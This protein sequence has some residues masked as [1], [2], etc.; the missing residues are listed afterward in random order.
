MKQYIVCWVERIG[1]TDTDH[2]QPFIDMDGNEDNLKAAQEFYNNLLEQDSTYTANLTEI[3]DS[4][5]Y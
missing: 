5:D 1:K 4:T 2:Y 3:I